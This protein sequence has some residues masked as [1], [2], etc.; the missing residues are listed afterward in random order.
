MNKTNVTNRSLLENAGRLFQ[1]I[2]L[3]QGPRSVRS[4]AMVDVMATIIDLKILKI[5]RKRVVRNFA[6]CLIK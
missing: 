6:L 1:A 4:S 3:T 2:S 5:A